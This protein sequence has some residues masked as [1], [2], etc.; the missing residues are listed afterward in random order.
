MAAAPARS[1]WPQ[2]LKEFSRRNAGRATRLEIDDPD[3]GAQWGQLELRF[4]GAAYEPRFRRVEIMLTD[5]SPT[6]HLT[7][8]VEAVTDVDVVLD[9]AGR[10]HVLRI[11]YPGGQMLLH[12]VPA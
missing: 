12:L 5:G 4:R 6:D 8:S 10:D 2:V 7:H 1:E 11:A 3:V 9:G